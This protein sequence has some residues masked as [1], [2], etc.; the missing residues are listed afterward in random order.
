M[1]N[2]LRSKRWALT[3][4]RKASLL[5]HDCLVRAY[6]CLI[7]AWVAYGDRACAALIADIRAGSFACLKV[8]K[9]INGVG[10]GC[11]KMREKVSCYR[12]EE[13]KKICLNFAKKNVRNVR[14][15]EWFQERRRPLYAWREST[16]Y[17]TY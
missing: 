8:L 10:L 11:G 16:N 7:R 9:S 5:H 13:R 2:K 15:S 14:C 12:E 1:A 17:P 4:L 3:K 6:K